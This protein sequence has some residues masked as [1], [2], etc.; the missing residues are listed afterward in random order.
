MKPADEHGWKRSSRAFCDSTRLLLLKAQ[1]SL[2][3]LI[4]KRRHVYFC[5]VHSRNT[6]GEREKAVSKVAPLTLALAFRT[7]HQWQKV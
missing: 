6:K 7:Y 3:I 5:L 1:E 4:C 2:Q